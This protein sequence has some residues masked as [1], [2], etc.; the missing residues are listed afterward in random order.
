MKFFNDTIGSMYWKAKQLTSFINRFCS[1]VSSW[2]LSSAFL[3]SPC[4]LVYHNLLT[5]WNYVSLPHGILD[6]LYSMLVMLLFPYA[7]HIGKKGNWQMFL[8]YSTMSYFNV[9]ELKFYVMC[10]LSCN[11]SHYF[12]FKAETLF[13]PETKIVTCSLCLAWACIYIF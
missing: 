4:L 8:A 7:I 9:K 13:Y 6:K 1:I 11:F 3:S 5:E 10:E 12:Y 2:W